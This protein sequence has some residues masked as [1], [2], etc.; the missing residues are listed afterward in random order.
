[1]DIHKIFQYI[2]FITLF[3]IAQSFSMWGQFVTLPYKELSMWQAYKMAIPFA[4]LDWL[5][6][7][8]TIYV[9]DKYELVTPTQD[10][11]LLIIIQ[12]T[13]IL[14]INQY[15]LKQKIYRSDIIAFFVI[16]LGFFISFN[17]IIS[18]IFNIT[19]PAHPAT[20]VSKT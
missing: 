10:T 1:M 17:H 18:N 4:W 16:L 15:Y 3:I 6:M 2:L 19:I 7:T 5:F 9:G 8:F 20:S 12:F 11:F 14:L 13:L